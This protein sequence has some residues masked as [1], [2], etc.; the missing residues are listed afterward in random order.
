MPRYIAFLR[1]INVGGHVVKMD[2]LRDLF[3]SLGLSRV[4]TFIASGNV[5]FESRSA[6]TQALEKKIARHL[7]A[8]LGYSV[9][10]FIRTFEEVAAIGAYQPF[11]E[12]NLKTA[13]TVS[14]GF[15]ADPPSPASVEAVMALKS[16]TDDFH[17]HGRE[18]YWLTRVSQAVSKMNNVA[19]EKRVKVQ[20]TFRSTTTAGKLAALV[21]SK[22]DPS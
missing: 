12:E 20:T 10:T 8:A 14:V 16:E 17:I 19:F 3:T 22:R 11:G 7:E 1:A 18:V 15:L 4:E 2:K 6:N 21:R 9:A 13:H 5:L